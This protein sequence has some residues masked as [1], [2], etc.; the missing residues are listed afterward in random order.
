MTDLEDAADA[1]GVL[2]DPTRVAILR[3]LASRFYGDDGRPVGFAELRRAVG[4]DDPGRFNYHLDTLRDR[5]VLKREGGY[6]PTVAGLKA[7]ESAEAGIYTDDTGPVTATIDDDCP[8]CGESLTATYENHWVSVHCDD[9]GLVFKTLV[10][11]SIGAEGDL[12]EVVRYAVGEVWRRID[13]ATDGVCS[14]CRTRTLSVE[15]RETEDAIVADCACENCYFEETNPV[16]LFALAHPAVLALLH[17]HG[18]DVPHRLPFES[19]DDW[20]GDARFVDD[21]RA[22]ELTVTIEGDDVTLR[23]A[24]DLTVETV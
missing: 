24:D 13:R 7:V 10:H 21:R 17:D 18:V 8:N 23:I 6:T 3:E 5:F 14:I 4:I 22:V 19:F 20:M 2:S 9:H 12:E 1:F 11:A 16:A 15:F